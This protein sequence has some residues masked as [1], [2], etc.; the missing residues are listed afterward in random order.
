[1]KNRS[2]FLK[3]QVHKNK[4]VTT[5]EQCLENYTNKEKQKKKENYDYYTT[6]DVVQLL[7]KPLA[8]AIKD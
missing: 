6:L 1:M 8:V 2:L 7:G 4:I 5:I 3:C